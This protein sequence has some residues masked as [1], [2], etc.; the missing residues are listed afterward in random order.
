MRTVKQISAFLENRPGQLAE[1]TKVLSDNNIDMRS[2]CLS[3]AAEFGI[4]R[5]IVDDAERAV[6]AL[7]KSGYICA[8]TPVIAA[9][10]PDRPGGLY[11]VLKMLSDEGVNIE[12]NYVFLGKKKDGAYN[13]F[14]VEQAC[15]DRAFD[16]L[17]RNGIEIVTQEELN[18][19]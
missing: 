6:A 19:L 12:Y 2:L 17:K 16:C 3:E 11:S 7:K 15:T 9:I 18:N 10:V 1:F 8:V 13:I 4:V 5:V 14:H